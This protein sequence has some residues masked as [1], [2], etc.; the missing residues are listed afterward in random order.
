MKILGKYYY[1]DDGLK[2]NVW[3]FFSNLVSPFRIF[4][5]SIQRLFIWFPVIWKD[6]D[7][8]YHYLYEVLKKKIELMSKFEKKY[9]WST[10]SE[11]VA[12]QMDEAVRLIDKV[13]DDCIEE[14]LEPFY[15]VY[16]NFNL[17]MSFS[18]SEDNLKFKTISF[19]YD[20]EEQEKLYDDCLSKADVIRENY[21]KKLFKL[22]KDKIDWWW[23]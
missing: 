12:K 18:D 15:N 1:K 8:D 19:K 23:D 5:D 16:P 21:K 4:L 7:W 20:S 22:L 11:E 10:K 13:N 17:E 3:S 14:A 6:R 2:L 9:A